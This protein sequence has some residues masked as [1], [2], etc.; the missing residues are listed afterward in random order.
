MTPITLLPTTSTIEEI[1]IQGEPVK[2]GS[3]YGI[4]TGQHTV[5]IYVQNF[6]GRVYIEGSISNNI[7]N[8]TW[9]PIDPGTGETYVEFPRIPNAATSIRGGDNGVYGFTFTANV[10]WLRARVERSYY[11]RSSDLTTDEMISLGSVRKIMM[12]L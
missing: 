3:W 6:T 2:A 9:F 12:C 4:P 1:D 10:L 8:A 5:A 11:L 7:S